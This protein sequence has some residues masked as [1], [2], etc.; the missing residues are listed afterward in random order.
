MII[1]S[2]T[3]IQFKIL[4]FIGLFMMFI[5]VCTSNPRILQS[6]MLLSGTNQEQPSNNSQSS[7]PSYGV[8][9]SPNN[10]QSSTPSYD[11]SLSPNQEQS[12]S[13]S[14]SLQNESLPNYGMFMSQNQDQ[15]SNTS[16]LSAFSQNT[17]AF[18]IDNNLNPNSAF[19]STSNNF[20][21]NSTFSNGS[22]SNTDIPEVQQV[23][24]RPSIAEPTELKD[25]PEEDISK[26]IVE[27]KEVTISDNIFVQ[28]NGNLFNLKAF[29]M[30]FDLMENP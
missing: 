21:S 9:M 18:G 16:Q 10:S 22:I 25:V 20:I 17:S 8:S 13:F 14:T 7:T 23:P 1:M 2:K 29:L 15:S 11:M 19:P 30:I 28:P 26:N 27:P 4:R 3:N 6:Y 5:L 12:S 24:Q